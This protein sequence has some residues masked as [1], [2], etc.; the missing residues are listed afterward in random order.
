MKN[1][2]YIVSALFGALLLGSV[3]V[4][5]ADDKDD[6]WKHHEKWWK[7][8]EK[9]RE[10]AYK[11]WRE[12]EKERAEDYKDWL[13]D[14]RERREEWLEDERERA[15][16]TRK[17][18]GYYR[19]AP[20]YAPQPYYYRPPAYAPQPYPYPYRPAPSYPPYRRGIWFSW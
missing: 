12:A 8:Q 3:S 11:K 10:K 9:H 14:Q 19:Y 7:E 6:R 4:G 2:P 15:E 13:E 17:H 20:P 16:E 1:A 5:H 18:G